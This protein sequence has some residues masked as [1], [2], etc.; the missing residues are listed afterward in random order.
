MGWLQ[1][2]ADVTRQ[3]PVLMG[4]GGRWV[5]FKLL[6]G[7]TQSIRESRPCS[8][9]CSNSLFRV[10]GLVFDAKPSQPWTVADGL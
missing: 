5:W 8:L 1:L 2:S 6:D 9:C 4:L 3:T 10:H 7:C